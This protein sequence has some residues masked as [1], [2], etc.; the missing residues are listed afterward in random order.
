MAKKEEMLKVTEDELKSLQEIVG[1][2][3]GATTRVGQ[4]ENQKHMV[5]HDLSLM[6][7]DLMK[8]QGELEATYGKVDVNIQ[9]GTITAR[10]DV[11]ADTKD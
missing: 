5:L 8:L 7:T 2:M 6:R 4:I 3:N 10:E 9:D 1:S 11:E